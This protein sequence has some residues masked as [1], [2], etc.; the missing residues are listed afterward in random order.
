MIVLMYAVRLNLIN[1]RAKA[2]LVAPSQISITGVRTL[3]EGNEKRR[4]LWDNVIQVSVLIQGIHSH[5]IVEKLNSQ[6]L[7]LKHSRP[8][9]RSWH[10]KYVHITL[11][12]WLLDHNIHIAE[13]R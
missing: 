4:I 12:T 7:Y 11:S 1:E 9:L 3:H 8:K 6:S 5:A 13:N 2:S 10:I